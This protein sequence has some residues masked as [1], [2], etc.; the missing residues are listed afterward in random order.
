MRL[1]ANENFPGDAIA[2][3]RVAG[4]DVVWMRDRSPG[5]SDQA[6]LQLAQAQ[7]RILLTFDKDFGE[8]A[9]RSKLPSSS[10]II[11][12]RLRPISPEYISSI[13]VEVLARPSEWNGH[14]AVV[15]ENR[16]R[17]VPL[18]KS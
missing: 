12:F 17:L 1:L 2:A 9:F 10:G 8:L 13:A 7:N 3:L 4:H 16:I 14:F 15:E 5:A 11:L 18:P 6:V